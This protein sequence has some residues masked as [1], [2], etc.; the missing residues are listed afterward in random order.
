MRLVLPRVILGNLGDLASR[1]GLLRALDLLGVEDVTVFSRTMEDLPPLAYPGLP[2]G[3]I[4]NLLHDRVGREAIKKA[5]TVVWA[6][7]LDMQDDSSLV[8]LLYLWVN[9]QIY[10]QMGKQVWVLFQGAGPLGTRPGKA[11]AKGVLGRVDLFAARDPGTYQLV[12]RL[13]PDLRR[14]LANDAIFFPGFEAD[15]QSQ[16]MPDWL[17]RLFEP[18]SRPVIGVNLRQWFHFASSLLPYQFSRKAYLER[19]SQKM[20]EVVCAM[21][22]IVEAL[23]R[24]M[25]AR[26]LLVS[27]YQPGVVPW[28]DDSGWLAQVKERFAGDGEVIQ[29]DQPL[30]IPEYFTLISRLKMMIGMRLHS[31]LIALRLGVPSINLSYTL[32]GNDILQHLGLGQNAI[33]LEK[34][35]QSP[36]P[37]LERSIQILKGWDAEKA[38]VQSAVA[39]ATSDNLEILRSL[40]YPQPVR[41]I[42]P[43]RAN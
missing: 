20:L 27:A 28:E 12:G 18:A 26:I 15:I 1:W 5:D 9:F 14:V 6:V 38:L 30:S 33:S 3:R 25:N 24:Q 42:A 39:K 35:L 10:K 41:N 36:E 13:Q 40:V 21:E 17:N 31:S 8:K 4:R 37:V 32:K 16:N 11:L 23:R 7:G 43:A 34:F 2:Y 22:K 19:S 29:I